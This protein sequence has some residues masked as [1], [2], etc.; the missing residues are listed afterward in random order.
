MGSRQSTQAKISQTPRAAG[1][2]HAGGAPGAGRSAGAGSAAVRGSRTALRRLLAA[3]VLLAAVLPHLRS[4]QY[5]FVWDDKFMIGPQIDLTGPADLGRLWNTPFD[6]LLRDPVLHNTY[7]RPVTLLS[8]ALDRAIYA[9]NPAGFHLTN[10]IVYAAA[11]LFL[12]LFAWELSGQPVLAAAGTC[13]FALHPTHPESV[14]FIAGRTDLLCG[15]FLFASLWAA[16]RWGPRSRSVWL[17]LWPA[18][19]FL[20]LSLWSKEVAVFAVPLPLLVLWLRDRSL[21]AVALARSAALPA[22]ALLIYSV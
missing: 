12:W 2:G 16:A 13:V 21:R 3:L 1:G 4:L 22:A 11:C 20:L 18:S 5:G 19:I 6:A 15:A 8:L 9:S 10:V 7:F 17:K 14:D